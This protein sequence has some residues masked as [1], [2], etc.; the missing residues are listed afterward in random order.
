MSRKCNVMNG[1]MQSPVSLLHIGAA[2]IATG[3]GTWILAAP[4]GTQ[5]HRGVGGVYS[6][7]MVI[8][9]TTAF[10][11]YRLFGRFGLVHWGAVGSWLALAVGLVP[12]AFRRQLP[13]WKAWHYTGM[14]LSITGLYATFLVEA[15]YRLF[16]AR[17]FWVSTVGTGS[18]V[19]SVGV[20]FIYRRLVAQNSRRTSVISRL[21]RILNT[22]QVTMGK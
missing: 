8:V 14:V 2:L 3:C 7:M 19:L 21:S 11:I 15:T 18:A 9:L 6:I 4:K 5:P 10:G 1:I 20:W 13:E 16:P 17:Y 12:L 22:M